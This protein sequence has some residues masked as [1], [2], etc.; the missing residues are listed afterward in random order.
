MDAEGEDE[1]ENEEPADANNGEQHQDV[2]DQ[3]EKVR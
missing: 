3:R 2:L 1:E